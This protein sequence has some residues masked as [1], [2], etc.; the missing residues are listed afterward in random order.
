MYFHGIELYTHV[1]MI[2]VVVGIPKIIHVS[3]ALCQAFCSS[4]C[5]LANLEPF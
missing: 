5:I 4:T 1:Y 2:V 3:L